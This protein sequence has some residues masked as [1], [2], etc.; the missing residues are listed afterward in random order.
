MKLKFM[1]E[2]HRSTKDGSA[3]I[4]DWV[5]ELA[6]AET[7]T[8]D[9]VVAQLSPLAL[10]SS[11]AG[12]EVRTLRLFLF[13][14]FRANT[15]PTTSRS[16]SSSSTAEIPVTLSLTEMSDSQQNPMA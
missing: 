4:I 6:A 11:D 15:F 16:A 7:T 5:D 14:V 3:A 10:P 8:L 9:C 2:F 13:L 12:D 1:L